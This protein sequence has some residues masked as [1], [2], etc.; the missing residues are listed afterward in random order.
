MNALVYLRCLLPATGEV[1]RSRGDALFQPSSIN[2][3]ISWHLFTIVARRALLPI[4]SAGGGGGGA[5]A[6]T[7]PLPKLDQTAC[8]VCLELFV[9]DETG[10]FPVVRSSP[11]CY[12]SASAAVAALLHY[13]AVVAKPGGK[14]WACWAQHS[15][16]RFESPCCPAPG[17]LASHVSSLSL[18]QKGC[19]SLLNH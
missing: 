6:S 3:T 16:L 5:A 9:A 19:F 12:L 13:V 11:R 17:L 15:P 18:F 8:V 10:C 2:I 7:E 4:G 1:G 14:W